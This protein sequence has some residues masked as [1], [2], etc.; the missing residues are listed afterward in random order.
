MTNNDSSNL[1]EDAK[2][3]FEKGLNEYENEN[4]MFAIDSFKKSLEIVP[5]RL[6]TLNNLISSFFKIGDLNNA[7]YYIKL[8]LCINPKDD[9]LLV[10]EGV[11][12]LKV[13]NLDL[14]LRSF[15]NAL[16]VNPLCCEAYSNIGL[17]YEILNELPKAMQSYNKATAINPDIIDVL[18]NRG[19]L[20]VKLG[21]NVKALCD[22]SRG[23]EINP[24]YQDLM[25]CYMAAKMQVCDWENYYED[26]GY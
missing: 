17:V 2:F 5:D 6:N 19:N 7:N 12:N 13:K 18:Y 15:N 16:I 25:A 4:Y 20:Y 3:F 1:I 14:A 21:D 26:K 22:F 23:L 24:N 11:F 8:G 9:L 10:N